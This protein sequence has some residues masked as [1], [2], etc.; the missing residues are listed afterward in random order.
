M[1]R[2][3]VSLLIVCWMVL[4][5]SCN[6]G[7]AQD[8]SCPEIVYQ[9]LSRTKDFCTDTRRNEAC[10]GNDVLSAKAQEN[11]TDFLFE[12][13]GDRESLEFIE[14]LALSPM[15][16]IAE[17]WGIAVL[18][19]QA[20]LPDTV[21]GQNVTFLIFGDVLIEDAPPPTPEF[22][23]TLQ[24]RPMQ[25]FY[26]KTAIGDAHCAESPDSGILIQTPQGSTEIELITNT[27]KITLGSTAYFQAEAGAEMTMSV[28][29]GHATASAFGVTV[30]VPAGTRVRIPI[31]A[32]LNATGA[33]S[34]PEPYDLV[35]L[36]SLPI[37][38]LPDD[39]IVS[40]PLMDEQ[41]SAMDVPTYGMWNVVYDS[42]FIEILNCASDSYSSDYS[43]L[44]SPQPDGSIIWR[45]ERLEDVGFGV[46]EF[47][48][49]VHHMRMVLVSPTQIEG[50]D[51]TFVPGCVLDNDFHLTFEEAL[52]DQATLDAVSANGINA[53]EANII[54]NDGI[55]LL[56]WTLGE[57]TG[58][59]PNNFVDGEITLEVFEEDDLIVT[60]A[61]PPQSNMGNNLY[62]LESGTARYTMQVISPV[63]IEGNYEV[64]AFGCSFNHQFSMTFDRAG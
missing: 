60:T 18:K 4:L 20:N 52:D 57:V 48:S 12:Q 28:L 1:M 38:N 40:P 34:I 63:S 26:F 56:T 42:P 13:V 15:D 22:E 32:D 47:I 16:T 44:L 54:P 14:S 58:T 8:D 50:Q 45:G 3:R 30:A 41:I 49:A 55:W 24:Y 7:L 25:A 6:I 53:G 46:Y 29:E 11:V 5:L 62:G 9:A 37:Q 31:D 64:I 2:Y 19:V 33:P 51:V 43:V 17:T 10:Y 27:V 35:R 36:A 21:P 61:F 23:D 39:I 59:C